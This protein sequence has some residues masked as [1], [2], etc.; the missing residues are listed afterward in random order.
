MTMCGGSSSH[1]SA[2]ASS[3]Y[4][5]PTCAPR[6]PTG[7]QDLPRKRGD[8]TVRATTTS[9]ESCPS[10]CC[11]GCTA[12]ETGGA[13]CNSIS[14]VPQSPPRWCVDYQQHRGCCRWLCR[15]GFRHSSARETRVSPPVY[16]LP[17]SVMG[18]L[19]GFASATTWTQHTTKNVPVKEGP[20][21]ICSN[22]S[23]TSYP[24]PGAGCSSSLR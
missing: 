18:C 21:R 2:T 16:C 11:F 1:P 17:P 3:L 12:V 13:T 6:R 19:K 14:S 23:H 9:R 15:F 20:T 7:L 4:P 8:H 5:N 10:C 22:T 24:Y